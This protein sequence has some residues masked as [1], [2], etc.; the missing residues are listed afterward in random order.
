MQT[1]INSIGGSVAATATVLRACGSCA[2]PDTPADSVWS[3]DTC[4]SAVSEATAMWTTS[5]SGRGLLEGQQEKLLQFGGALG[6]RRVWPSN[7]DQQQQLWGKTQQDT[8][9]CGTFSTRSSSLTRQ[10]AAATPFTSASTLMSPG[11]TPSDSSVLAAVEL[12]E[13]KVQRVLEYVAASEAS[14]VA[15]ASSLGHTTAA[16]LGSATTCLTC[17]KH[18]AFSACTCQHKSCGR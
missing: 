3:A 2:T 15:I 16:N 14:G 18:T 11:L 8:T 7:Q 5:H 1:C 10:A 12:T 13:R 4:P 6:D 17:L 9:T